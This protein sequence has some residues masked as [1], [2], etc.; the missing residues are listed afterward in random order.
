[1]IIVLVSGL[2]GFWQER[3]AVNAVVKLLA[4]VQIKATVIRQGD[5]KEVPVEE[6]VPGDRFRPLPI[7]FFIALGAI[8]VLYIISAE[9]AKRFF[10]KNIRS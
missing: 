1:M 2:L 7:P 3:G 10:Y 4:I 6:I 5:S 8:V 9:I